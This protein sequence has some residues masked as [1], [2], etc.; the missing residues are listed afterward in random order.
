VP[1]ETGPANWLSYETL[2]L[3]CKHDPFNAFGREWQAGSKQGDQDSVLASYECKD[4]TVERKRDAEQWVKKKGRVTQVCTII[5]VNCDF[6][7]VIYMH[8]DMIGS[9]LGIEI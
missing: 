1:L 3:D 8:V 9:K 5:L 4:G 2:T 6:L 7:L